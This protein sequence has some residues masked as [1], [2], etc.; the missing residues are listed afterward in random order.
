MAQPVLQMDSEPP[1]DQAQ[2]A[3]PN[4]HGAPEP[5]LLVP[6]PQVRRGWRR[7]LVDPVLTRQTLRLGLPV[8]AGMLTQTAINILDTVMVGRLP[9][10]LANPGQAAIQ[11]TLPLMW[12]VGGFL[13]AVWVG[14]Q[15][16]TARRAGEG[17]D[18]FAGRALTNSLFISATA[19]VVLTTAAI[20]VAPT[21]LAALY[22][23]PK[24]VE[25]GNDY[26][27][28]RLVGVLAMA[29]TFSYKSFFDGIGRTRVFM[30]V[31]IVMNVLNVVLNYTLIFGVEA[32]GIPALA[33]AGAAWASV[34]AAYIGLLLLV[35]W[36]FRPSLLGRYRYYTLRNLNL[37]VLR[38]IVRLS[39]PNGV[40]TIVVMVGF[41]G[42]YWVVGQ[43]NDRYAVAGNPVVS[44]ANAALVTLFMISF[45]TALA[46]GMAT[47]TLVSQ[48]LG[49]KRPFLAERYAL[50]AAKLWAYVMWGIGLIFFLAPEQV[51]GLINPDPAVIDLAREPLQAIAVLQGVAA[52]ALVLAQTLYGVGLARY[53]MVVEFC[54]HLFIVS[55]VAYLFGVVLDL[56]LMG[57]YVGPIL[58][59]G[60]LAVA[61]YWRFKRGDWKELRI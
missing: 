27:R 33:V 8:V 55:P 12:L 26:L 47:A 7:L 23:D 53:V 57:V 14:T 49:A 2:P 61:M 45:M 60:I 54:L 6:D 36:S 46:F 4:D 51:L 22:S 43:V 11:A 52:I 18:L 34:I 16:I 39:L 50:N 1:P 13:S 44:T 17:H 31:A 58:Y 40:A 9:P 29:T 19:G 48:S 20:L 24:V 5:F 28:A 30:N 41:V 32:V 42:F 25:L 3:P 35:T 15:A 56:G 37:D 59:A 10:E 38:E 21:L